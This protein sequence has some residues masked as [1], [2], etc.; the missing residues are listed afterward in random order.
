MNP[1][2]PK[3]TPHQLDMFTSP[4]IHVYQALEE[5]IFEMIARRLKTS[6]DYSS[7]TVLEWQVD[8]LNQLR[9]VNNDTIKALS[10]TTGVAEKGIRKAIRETGI[11]T[12]QSVDYELKDV[13]PALP[14]PTQ[15]DR[16]LESYINQTFR[17]LDNYVNQT[18]ITTNFGQGSVM[19]MYRK[20]VEETT[21][22][23]LAG[24]TTTN[25]AVAETV[26]KWANKGIDTAFIDRG[27]H[28]W[29]LERYAETVIRS[30]VNRTYNELRM[31]RMQEYD[32]DLVLVSALP[33]P[34]DICGQIQ[35]KVAS[36]KEPSQN[37][38]NYPSIYD[39]GYGEPGGIRG[40]NCRHMFFP[41]VEGIMENN[42]P[43]YSQEDMAHNRELRQKQRYHER[44]I[45][46]AKRS[47]KLAEIMGDDE[48]ISKQKKLLRNRQARIREFISENNLT[49]RYENERVIV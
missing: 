48:T 39:F 37:D 32:V 45:R 34:R 29:N 19:S 31:S 13:R 2:K 28:I 10:K 33:D 21:G 40:I 11:A 43:Q 16:I 25:K 17:E 18:L 4:V 7:D 41:F 22:K 35:G 6:R 27:G 38:S 47:V 30:T 1:K 24:I 5:E 49:R 8:K 15:I 9:M 26:I 14:M 12:I 42:Q 20:I 23:V 3:I 44:Q 36:M 46:M